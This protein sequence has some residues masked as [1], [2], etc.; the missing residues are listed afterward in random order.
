MVR[1]YELVLDGISLDGCDSV[2]S[3]SDSI[4]ILQAAN[5]NDVGLPLLPRDNK[6][7]FNWRFDYRRNWRG[8]LISKVDDSFGAERVL[9]AEPAA[10][11]IIKKNVLESILSLGEKGKD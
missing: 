7:I 8:S 2:W 4:R 9:L 3:E 1:R 10:K 6:C 5:D 11:L